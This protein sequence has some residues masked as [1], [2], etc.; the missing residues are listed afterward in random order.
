M[1]KETT[2]ITVD[3]LPSTEIKIHVKKLQQEIHCS[4][5]RLEVKEIEYIN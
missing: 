5:I 2:K 3:S 4:C 1:E